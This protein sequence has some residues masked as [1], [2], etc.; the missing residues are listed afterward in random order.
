[1]AFFKKLKDKLFKSS[2]KLEEGLDE[3]VADGGSLEMPDPEDVPSPPTPEPTPEPE[4][5]PNEPNPLP[6]PEP[7]PIPAE[8]D[9]Q[10]EP[11]PAP[12]P[13]TEQPDLPGPGREIPSTPEPQ[14]TPPPVEVPPPPGEMPQAAPMEIP[15][16][17]TDAQT[18]GK[19]GFLGR[20]MGRRSDRRPDAPV[21]RRALDD[22]ML[23]SLEELFITSD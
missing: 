21:M 11:Q 14:P 2:S 5:V 17:A 18:A 8:P 12:T 15:P 3:I 22:E 23:E 16:P 10:P 6:A 19:P 1:M 4:P 7:E 20:L 13:P 9:P